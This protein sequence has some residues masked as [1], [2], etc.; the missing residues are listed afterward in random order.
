MRISRFV[1]FLLV[2]VIG[3]GLGL[4]YGWV[5]NPPPYAN[6]KLDTLRSDYKADYVLMAAEVY[7]KDNNLAQAVRQLALLEDQP[8]ERVV[9]EALL[10]AR[11]LSYTQAD[12]ETLAYLSQ[13]LQTSAPPPAGGT[14]SPAVIG[15]LSPAS[16]G[17][18]SPAPEGTATA[19][20]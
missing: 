15:T 4:A 8:P 20:P 7:R 19:T 13:A 16:E 1:L 14:A 6:L 18:A 12:L 11:D 10:T 17:T 3:A 5:I 2:M 9:A